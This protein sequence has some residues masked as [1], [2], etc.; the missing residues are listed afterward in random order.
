[1]LVEGDDLAGE[2]HRVVDEAAQFARLGVAVCRGFVVA[3]LDSQPIIRH[4]GDG[5]D[6]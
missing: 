1:L 4:G 6:S 2:H 5:P 3:A